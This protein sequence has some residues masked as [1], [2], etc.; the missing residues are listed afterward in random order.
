M[1]ESGACMAKMIQICA[2]QNDLFGL[3]DDGMVYQYNFKTHTWMTIG[4]GRSDSGEGPLVERNQ[5]FSKLPGSPDS[6]PPD[7]APPARRS[8]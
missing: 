7:A 2:S 8:E 3:D 6:A 4:H 5:R 1:V